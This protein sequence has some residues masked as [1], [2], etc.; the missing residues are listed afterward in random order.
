VPDAVVAQAIGVSSSAYF[1]I[2][3][4]DD[5]LE[6]LV[7]LSSVKALCAILGLDILEL[8][9]LDTACRPA[10]EEE[11]R[12]WR[13]PRRQLVREARERAGLS[14]EE[15][16]DAIGY[17][18]KEALELESREDALESWRIAE[19]VGLATILNVPP[20]LLLGTT[21]SS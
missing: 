8:F 6:R 21:G 14:V 7:P 20:Q 2:E 1:D 18:V 3:L 16:A 12:R 13:L 9:H 5:E 17:E 4:H 11:A 15:L 19:I 10:N